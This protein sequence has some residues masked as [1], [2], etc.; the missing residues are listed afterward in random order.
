MSALRTRELLT[1]CSLSYVVV[2]VGGLGAVA[3]ARL[4]CGTA[5]PCILCNRLQVGESNDLRNDP[6]TVFSAARGRERRGGLALRGQGVLG[7]TRWR[8]PDGPGRSS[9]VR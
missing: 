4:R 1:G 7:V 9:C 2:S 3:S 5:N 8:L 6:A